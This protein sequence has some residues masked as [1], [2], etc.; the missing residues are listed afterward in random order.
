M[1][2]RKTSQT[3]KIARIEANLDILKDNTSQIQEEIKVMNQ[4]LAVNTKQLEIHIEGVRL[5]REQN[6]ILRKDVDA[7]FEKAAKD[8]GPIRDHV[9]FVNQSVKIWLKIIGGLFALPACLY[10]LISIYFKMKG[11]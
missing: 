7:R 5:A 11:N 4:I 2:D 10:Y 1:S 9:K 6:E 8:L 3:E